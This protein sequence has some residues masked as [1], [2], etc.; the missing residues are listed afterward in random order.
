MSPLLKVCACGELTS[1]TPCPTCSAKKNQQR[2]TRPK[3]K[4]IWQTPRW[5]RVRAQ[6]L[7]NAEGQCESC[8]RR[9]T[10]VHHATGYDDPFDPAGMVALCHTCHGKKHGGAH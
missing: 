6:V 4:A 10:T 8:G 2:N 9:A 3:A 7:A 1:F 5:R